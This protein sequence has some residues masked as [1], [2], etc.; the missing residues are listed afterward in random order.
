ML[1]RRSFLKSLL[2]ATATASSPTLAL[3]AFEYGADG[4][5]L[6]HYKDTDL[7]Q[8]QPAQRPL[9]VE[10]ILNL[11]SGYTGERWTCHFRDPQGNYNAEH[12]Q[13]LNWFLRCS[14]DHRYTQIDVRV[15]EMLNYLAKWF[16]ENPE[17]TV[18]SAYRTPQ[19][20]RVLARSN[21]NVAKNSLHIR[22]QAVDF[23]IHGV[24][25]RSVC[26]VAQAV[27]NVAG[28]GGVGYYPRQNFVHIDCGG[29]AATWVR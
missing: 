6:P 5:P 9:Y 18:N 27:R 12:L 28:S 19:Y 15:I 14:Y 26:Q 2:V 10:G 17:I 8:L 13:Y 20:N 21:E 1:S 29:R 24:P 16:P 22:G 3:G 4:A 23:S 11:R 25:I 7:E